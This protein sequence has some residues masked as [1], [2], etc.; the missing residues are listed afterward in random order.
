MTLLPEVMLTQGGSGDLNSGQCDSRT[1][2]PAKHQAALFPQHSTDSA[3]RQLRIEVICY[4]VTDSYRSSH[5]HMDGFKSQNAKT[6]QLNR[7]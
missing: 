6:W 3:T 4:A 1:C 7:W 5:Q 2:P